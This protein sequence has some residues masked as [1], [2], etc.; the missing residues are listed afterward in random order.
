LKKIPI[1]I[2][3]FHDGSAGQ[4]SEWLE[5]VSDFTIACYFTTQPYQKIDPI[6]ENTKRV[7]RKMEYPTRSSYRSKPLYWGKDWVQKI[8]KHA[9]KAVLPLDPD[10]RSR[11]ATIQRCH[12]NG[13]ALASAIHPSAIILPKTTIANGVWIHAKALIG[14]KTDISEGTIINSG[15]IIEH[16]NVLKSCAQIDPGVITTGGCTV[17]ERGHVHTGAILINRVVIGQD[18]R[19]GA[20]SLVRRNVPSSSIV[21]GIPAKEL[22]KGKK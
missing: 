18:A 14:F 5:S 21:V 2:S 12:K 19:V 7:S 6:L 15:S 8:K 4:I 3:T 20:C 9:V 22:K 13:F 1:A 11:W 10:N 17:L 16:H